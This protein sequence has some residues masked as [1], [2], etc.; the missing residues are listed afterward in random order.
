M[1]I[2]VQDRIRESLREHAS[3]IEVRGPRPEGVFE[4]VRER[5]LRRRTTRAVV[6]TL[7]IALIG[8]GAL[9]RGSSTTVKTGHAAN[10]STGATAA[11]LSHPAMIALDGWKVTF[12]AVVDSYTE[13][14]FT[15]ATRKLQVSF[16]DLGSR[17][18]NETNPTEVTLRGTTGV[19][20]DEGAPR[21]RVDWDE[22]GQTWEADGEPFVDVNE[23]VSVLEQLRVI[24]EATWKAGLPDGIGTSILANSDRGVTWYDDDKGLSC[25]GPQNAVPCS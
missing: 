9:S 5:R 20:T 10:Q 15:D 8:F 17:T 1:S 12:I 11:A 6:A 21:Y 7:A 25:F 24:D 3:G 2:D 18:G 14:Q 13:Y 19:T 22:Q 16:Y 4:R 23:F